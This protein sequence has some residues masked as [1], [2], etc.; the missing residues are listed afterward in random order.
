MAPLGLADIILPL[1]LV[2]RRAL[3]A[4]LARAVTRPPLIQDQHLPSLFHYAR[5]GVSEK[6]HHR[7]KSLASRTT[8]Q[9]CPI[10]DRPDPLLLHHAHPPARRLGI[11][12]ERPCQ[13][14]YHPRTSS[15]V[16]AVAGL[17]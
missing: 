9:P 1:G 11:Q 12:H 6:Q 3:P 8:G 10:L 16:P 17:A 15:R 13:I 5:P 14:A 4:G 2:L 7:P